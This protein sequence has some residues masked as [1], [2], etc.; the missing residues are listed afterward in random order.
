MWNKADL[1]PWNEILRTKGIRGVG[2]EKGSCIVTHTLSGP[3]IS[4]HPELA[5]P[6]PNYRWISRQSLPI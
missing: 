1:H 4:F 3:N 6:E 2:E 5:C